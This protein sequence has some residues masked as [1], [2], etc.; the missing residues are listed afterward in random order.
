MIM[1][2]LTFQHCSGVLDQLHLE[3]LQVFCKIAIK[4]LRLTKTTV[5]TDSALLMPEACAEERVSS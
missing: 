1:T 4:T 5:Q 2:Q 3:A